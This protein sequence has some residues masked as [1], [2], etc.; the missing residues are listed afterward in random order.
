MK[1]L[2]KDKKRTGINRTTAVALTTT[3]T[4][5]TAATTTNG[6]KRKK[7]YNYGIE[8]A[9]QARTCKYFR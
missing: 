1:K 6:R 7:R 8:R 2:E 9:R 3:G 5:R 4:A